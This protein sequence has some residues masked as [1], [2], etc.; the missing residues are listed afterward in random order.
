ME[1][2]IED[3]A[4]SFLRLQTSPFTY[5]IKLTQAKIW[6]NGFTA[7][8]H[9]YKIMSNAVIMEKIQSCLPGI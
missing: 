8:I 6:H 1:D 7:N 9:L 5:L 4:Y 3:T 2:I